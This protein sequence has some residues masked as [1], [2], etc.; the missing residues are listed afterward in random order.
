M[1]IGERFNPHKRFRGI[2]VP[3]AICKYRGI[4]PGA[5]LVYGRLCRYSGQDGKV[6]PA[7]STL[8]DE[9]GISE[10]QAREYVQELERGKFIE[11][12]RENKHYRKNGTGGTN[13][14]LFLWHAAF[15]GDRG[16]PRNAPPP[17]QSTAGGTLQQ[18]APL[19][20][21]VDCGQRE[22]I[23]LRE[24]VKESQEQADSRAAPRKT[25]EANPVPRPTC[26]DNPKAE[27]RKADP[28]AKI[29]GEE[30]FS[31]AEEEKPKADPRPW[32]GIDVSQIRKLLSGFMEGEEPPPNLMKWICTTFEGSCPARNVCVALE[33]AW[34]RSA[35]PGKKNAPRKWNWFYTTLRNALIPGE[36]GR[37]PEQPA[38]PHPAHQATAEDIARGID[39]LDSL[40][41]SYT[42]KCGAEIRQYSDRVV[43]SCTCG[44][45]KPI[46]RAAVTR[47]PAPG[48]GKRR[49]S[50][51]GRQ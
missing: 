4:S 2:F 42:C 48:E 43:G 5:K 29:A 7:I 28:P 13:T 27:A 50:G 16:A 23:C 18:T 10:T 46:A 26:A 19:T 21:A 39:V 38:A 32:T 33:A 45:A 51:D 44:R 30:N 40:V 15:E 11:V 41:A 25:G 12:D 31:S 20:P 6:Y 47:M 35:A 8:A 1:N 36:A 14:Y 3:E 22:S 34:S 49:L 24:S 17:P 37:L 9:V